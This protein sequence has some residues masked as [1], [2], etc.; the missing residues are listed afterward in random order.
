MKSIGTKIDIR[1]KCILSFF[2]NSA[3]GGVGFRLDLGE[4]DA[5][6]VLVCK[7]LPQL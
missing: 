4:G 5:M 1:E 6:A 2:T 7:K 3:R